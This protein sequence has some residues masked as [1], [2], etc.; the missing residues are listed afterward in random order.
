MDFKAILERIELQVYY[1][2]YSEPDAS[3]QLNA[4]D[5]LV[6]AGSSFLLSGTG[7]AV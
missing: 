5:G 7:G 6:Q 4:L 2:N 1:F 3:H